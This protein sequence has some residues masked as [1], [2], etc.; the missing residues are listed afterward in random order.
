M[1]PIFDQNLVLFATSRASAAYLRLAKRMFGIFLFVQPLVSIIY[2]FT[3]L[4]IANWSPNCRFC[5]LDLYCGNNVSLFATFRASISYLYLAQCN[6]WCWFIW[7]TICVI[8]LWIYSV[9]IGK[10]ALK[11]T[12]LHFLPPFCPKF[13]P[14]CN[15]KCLY[16][17]SRHCKLLTWYLSLITI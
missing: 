1:T 16:N 5:I 6:F 11:L 14:F 4:K 8:H 17:L 3:V 2:S 9:S 12:I 10:L 15:F 7:I 13:G